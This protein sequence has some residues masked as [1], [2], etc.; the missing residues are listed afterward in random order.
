MLWV[1]EPE[2]GLPLL[3][4]QPVRWIHNLGLLEYNVLIHVARVDEF[5]TMEGP[6]WAR[7]SP[8]S[9]GSGLPSDGSLE[10]GFRTT[11]HVNW[12]AGIQD[13]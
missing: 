5:V 13:L 8:G 7:R 2:D 9:D 1:P 11:R 12:S 3:G 6:A 4:P 10:E